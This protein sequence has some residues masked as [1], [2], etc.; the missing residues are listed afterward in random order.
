MVEAMLKVIIPPQI[1]AY[2]R[3]VINIR[4][5]SFKCKTWAKIKEWLWEDSKPLPL[6]T[7]PD[8]LWKLVVLAHKIHDLAQA[9]ID[10]C[11][12]KCFPME[13]ELLQGDPFIEV[14]GRK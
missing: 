14:S 11:L 5:G 2:M 4:K 12:E 7:S 1:C 9:C 8:M 13:P 6:G 10:R 3:D